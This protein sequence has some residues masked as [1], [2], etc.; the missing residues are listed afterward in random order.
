MTRLISLD[1]L[2]NMG[3]GA[4]V[5]GAR[6][7]LLQFRGTAA[8]F[9]GSNNNKSF[10]AATE[11]EKVLPTSQCLEV[12]QVYHWVRIVSWT[13]VEILINAALSCSSV[14]QFKRCFQTTTE[15]REE[16]KKS[17]GRT[18]LGREPQAKCN[19]CNTNLSPAPEGN[20][21]ILPVVRLFCAAIQ[22]NMPY[23]Y[24]TAPRQSTSNSIQRSLNLH[25][26]QMTAGC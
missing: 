17:K 24:E 16:D 6:R 25:S 21:G 15:S 19:A 14:L 20:T 1:S 26:Q 11:P 22:A 2:R 23:S 7:T 18:Y 4:I 5:S 9:T 8:T 13:F 3:R 10:H 12:E